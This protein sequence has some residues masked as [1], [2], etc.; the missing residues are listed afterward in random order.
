[1]DDR[2]LNKAGSSK[3][4]PGFWK[5][6]D[7][8]C[9]LSITAVCV[10]MDSPTLYV[11]AAPASLAASEA[12]VYE[13]T[14]EGSSPVGNLVEGSTFEYIGDVTAEDGSVWRQITTVNG[15]TG[16]IKGDLEIVKGEEE[17]PAEGQEVSTEEN[18]SP[19]PA[20][21]G[22]EE[23]GESVGEGTE[24]I[25]EDIGDESEEDGETPDEVDG[26][27]PADDETMAVMNRRGEGI[28]NNQSKKYILDNS[29]KIKE[30]GNLAGINTDIG[31]MESKRAGIDLTL[32]ISIAVIFFCTGIVYI[33][34]NRVKMLKREA[35]IEGVLSARSRISKKV[36]KK[37]HSKKRK[38][39]K[40]GK[41]M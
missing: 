24:Q 34:M 10:C 25:P 3:K 29:A 8:V 38:A 41:R 6:R 4:V 13:Q 2:K 30:R 12:V 37:K 22:P 14:D 31:Q 9:M 36:E 21:N 26:Q 19:A 18:N 28:Q 7:M 11:Q 23:G 20:E 40:M 33:C 17:P 1:M 39:R 16:Y 32:M 5:I 27:E 35:D 15:A